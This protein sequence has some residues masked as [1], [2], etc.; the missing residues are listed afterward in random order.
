MFLSICVF[1]H[2]TDM[3]IF[4]V[5]LHK[6]PGKVS[7]HFG[8]KYWQLYFLKGRNLNNQ[9]GEFTFY[10]PVFGPF[11][12]TLLL[13]IFFISGHCIIQPRNSRKFKLACVKKYPKG[14]IVCFDILLNI[15][16]L[17]R[18]IRGCRALDYIVFFLKKC[19][20]SSAGK[21]HAWRHNNTSKSIFFRGFLSHFSSHPSPL[22]VFFYDVTH[23][24]FRHFVSLP[25]CEWFFFFLIG[26]IVQIIS[27]PR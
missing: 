2:W 6:G 27:G 18:L 9:R 5:K 19:D 7:S 22:D 16:T 20:F 10:L 12:T 1:N 25:S 3:V 23:N 15:T 13:F 4:T 21:C 11:Q 8:G 14:W 17:M 24:T 26:Y